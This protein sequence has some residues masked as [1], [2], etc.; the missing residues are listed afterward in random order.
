MWVSE[1]LK[2]HRIII[3]TCQ[4][5]NVPSYRVM[6]EIGMRRAKVFSANAYTATMIPAGRSLTRC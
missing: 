2:L 4:P 5:E 6:E 1:E 3:A